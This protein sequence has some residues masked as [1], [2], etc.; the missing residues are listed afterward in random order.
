M[1]HLPQ[2]PDWHCR[3]CREDWPCL[4]ARADLLTEYANTRPSLGMY[5]AAQMMDAVLDLGHPLDA[6]MYDRFLSW[7]R[8]REP[9]PAWLAPT[10]RQSYS[11]RDIVQ[12]AQQILDTH[13]RLPAT[14]LCAACGA[15][16]CPRRAGA[17]RI[18]YSRYGRLRCG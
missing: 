10:P 2:R 15:D 9:K 3:A 17:I 8:P 5:L 13:V 14:G 7:V 11:R 18:L 16:R 12:R 6:A 4:G 1:S